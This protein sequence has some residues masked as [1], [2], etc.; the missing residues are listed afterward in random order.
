MGASDDDE[1]EEED[2]DEV[3]GLLL[4]FVDLLGVVREA[5]R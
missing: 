1:D 3:E 4:G 5:R 2:D